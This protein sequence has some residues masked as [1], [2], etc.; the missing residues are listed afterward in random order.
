MSELSAKRSLSILRRQWKE[1]HNGVVVIIIDEIE[2]DGTS[3]P[4]PFL[5]NTYESKSSSAIRLSASMS[6]GSNTISFG[7]KSKRNCI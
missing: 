2:N 3:K 4:P 5:M 7:S 6:I 1:N